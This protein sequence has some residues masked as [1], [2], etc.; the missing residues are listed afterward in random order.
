MSTTL[1]DFNFSMAQPTVGE[2]IVHKVAWN[3]LIDDFERLCQYWRKANGNDAN[4]IITKV[5]NAQDAA[6]C[7][8]VKNR[9]AV[10][11]GIEQT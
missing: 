2:N 1:D 6:G 11:I 8:R 4:E 3:G 10:S 5:I 9:L 7:S